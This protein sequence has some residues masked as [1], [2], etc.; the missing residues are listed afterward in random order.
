MLCMAT[1]AIHRP[2]RVQHIGTNAESCAHLHVQSHGTGYMMRMGSRRV[3]LQPV[4]TIIIPHQDLA[5][6]DSHLREF[7]PY[8]QG[9]LNIDD[10]EPE[11]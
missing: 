1:Y 8:N 10:I 4:S 9:A 11:N 3:P 7:A 6:V 5:G 2:A